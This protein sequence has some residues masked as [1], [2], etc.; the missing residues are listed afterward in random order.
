MRKLTKDKAKCEKFA[1]IDGRR[2]LWKDKDGYW[3]AA[4]DRNNTPDFAVETEDLEDRT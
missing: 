3:H 2:V 1:R 4:T